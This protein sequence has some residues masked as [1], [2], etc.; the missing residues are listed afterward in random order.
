MRVKS[1]RRISCLAAGLIVAAVCAPVGAQTVRRFDPR[2]R[3]LQFGSTTFTGF[4]FL[5]PGFAGIASGQIPFR[6]IQF[7]GFGARYDRTASRAETATR[8]GLGRRFA[9]RSREPSFSEFGPSSRD[10]FAERRERRPG[11]SLI[12]ANRADRSDP[13]STTNGR[14]FAGSRTAGNARSVSNRQSLATGPGPSAGRWRLARHRR[15]F[16]P[17]R[18]LRTIAVDD[19]SAAERTAAGVAVPNIRT[20]AR[21][22]FRH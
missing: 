22:P 18:P 20:G 7:P 5:Q 9:S 1:G 21:F 17:L 6:G 10:R 3:E 15:P 2:D 12:A 4:R 11:H 16:G 14:R 8:R 13:F 19:R